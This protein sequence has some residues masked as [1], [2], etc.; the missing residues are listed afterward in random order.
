M[1]GQNYNEYNPNED[2]ET[3][4]KYMNKVNTT[5]HK[6]HDMYVVAYCFSYFEHGVLYPTLNQWEAFDMA[7]ETLGIKANT[8]KNT[9]DSFDGHNDNYRS[10][11]HQKPL[12]D[13]MQQF[14]NVY[15][16]KGKNDVINE[17]KNI[18]GIKI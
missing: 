12:S 13:K 11:W 1:T 6:N 4:Y 17:A 18:L 9:R 3:D 5:K 2:F 15:E 16:N 10:G 8:L 7:A 14:K